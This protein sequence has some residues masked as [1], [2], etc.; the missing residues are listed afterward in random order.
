[1]LRRMYHFEHRQH[2]DGQALDANPQDLQPDSAGSSWC[3]VGRLGPG[4]SVFEE[5]GA[6]GSDRRQPSTRVVGP[7][8]DDEPCLALR[9]FQGRGGRGDRRLPRSAGHR[10]AADCRELP[11]RRGGTAGR[12]TD[13]GGA[14]DSTAAG[15]TAA[16]G[17]EGVAVICDPRQSERAKLRRRELRA[18]ATAGR[19]LMEMEALLGELARREQDQVGEASEYEGFLSEPDWRGEGGR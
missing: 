10:P 15:A 18:L 16:P 3:H 14:L 13:G 6:I 4:Q 17:V 19:L 11:G 7:M 5:L 8:G 9:R 2:L 12:E 1:M